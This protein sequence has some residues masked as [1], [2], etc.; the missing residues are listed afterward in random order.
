MYVKID[1]YFN[2]LIKD[3]YQLEQ[4]ETTKKNQQ[5][6]LKNY[7]EIKKNVYFWAINICVM[8]RF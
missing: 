3:A 4:R 5:F 2:Q 7:K 8:F 6:E 1:V